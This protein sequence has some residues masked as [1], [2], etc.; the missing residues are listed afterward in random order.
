[1]KTR[2]RCVNIDRRGA[3]RSAR[4]LAVLECKK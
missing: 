2:K 3:R 1:M 4:G